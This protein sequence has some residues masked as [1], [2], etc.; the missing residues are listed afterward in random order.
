M[1]TGLLS[2]SPV[3]LGSGEGTT[4]VSGTAYHSNFVVVHWPFITLL[5][6][7]VVL[8]AVALAWIIM[9]TRKLGVDVVKS[10]LLPVLFGI[11]PDERRDALLDGRDE[12]VMRARNMAPRVVSNLE[13]GEDGWLLKPRPDQHRWDEA[14]IAHD[15][16]SSTQ[17]TAPGPK[18]EA[19]ARVD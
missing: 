8:S 17:E 12:A 4:R 7:Q 13:K 1:R 19:I 5:A 3:V 11:D 16:D 10:E 9:Q 2:S 15:L 14:F 18:R 6:A